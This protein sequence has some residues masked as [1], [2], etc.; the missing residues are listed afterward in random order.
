MEID[1]HDRDAP[2]I[3]Q[4][5]TSR[6]E[7]KFSFNQ[8]DKH[9]YKNMV[10]RCSHLS[11]VQKNTLLEL[12]AIYEDLFAGTIGKVP[13]VSVYL[14]LKPNAVP[15]CSRPYQIPQAI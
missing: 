14:E 6:I 8:Y 9:N 10:L 4:R 5:A 12:F 1:I 13:N 11:T 2:E 3:V 7:R 15:Y